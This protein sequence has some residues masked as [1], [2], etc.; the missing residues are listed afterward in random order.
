MVQRWIR[1]LL[2][3]TNGFIILLSVYLYM[4]VWGRKAEA[5]RVG[6]KQKQKHFPLFFVQQA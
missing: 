6:E 5:K 2:P 1:L 3:D 4:S